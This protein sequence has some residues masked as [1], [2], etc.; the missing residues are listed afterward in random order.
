MINDYLDC[1]EFFTAL[2]IEKTG[3]PYEE[4]ERRINFKFLE[5]CE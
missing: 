1:P 3:L 5:D 4:F 2:E